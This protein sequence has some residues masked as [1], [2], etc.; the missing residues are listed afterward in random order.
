M[1]RHLYVIAAMVK[2]DLIG[3]MPL[4][5]I[6]SSSSKTVCAQMPLAGVVCSQLQRLCGR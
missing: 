3:L 1:K 2:K 5:L 6:M 4:V